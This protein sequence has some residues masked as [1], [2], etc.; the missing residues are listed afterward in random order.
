MSYPNPTQLAALYAENE[1]AVQNLRKLSIIS[2]ENLQG[3][4][5]QVLTR[6]ASDHWGAMTPEARE[7]LLQHS[8][9]FVRS[10]AAVGQQDL[11]KAL[12]SNLNEL[13]VVQLKLRHQDLVR[14]AAEMVVNQEAQA[15]I[16]VPSSPANAA[17]VSLNV[18]M[19]T[20]RTR[21]TSLGHA[22]QPENFVWI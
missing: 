17:M 2:A 10:C 7:V 1:A 18:E 13:N 8:H 15:S 6:L 5:R 9:H 21:L 22:E 14:R 12:G 3:L 16:L 11:A 4:N 19:A 20:I